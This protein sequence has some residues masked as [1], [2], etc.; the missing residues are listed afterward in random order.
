[1]SLFR[2]S[3]RGFDQFCLQLDTIVLFSGISKRFSETVNIDE[4][5]HVDFW[6]KEEN[7][8]ESLVVTARV[9]SEKRRKMSK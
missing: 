5:V 2:R 1:M 3:S 7:I 4:Q 6:G 9:P 8:R